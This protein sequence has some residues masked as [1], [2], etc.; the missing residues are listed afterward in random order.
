MAS[1]LDE[2]SANHREK[3]QR[4]RGYL[5]LYVRAWAL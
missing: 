4:A 2:I 5:N 1:W 3:H